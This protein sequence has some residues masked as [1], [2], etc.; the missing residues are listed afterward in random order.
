MPRVASTT[1]TATS[2]ASNT[3][4]ARATRWFPRSPSSSMP[5]VS[6][7]S[8]GPTGSSSMAFRTGSVVVPAVSDTTETV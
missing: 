8:T 2:A 5:G 6:I 1:S 3:A 7:T 4:V